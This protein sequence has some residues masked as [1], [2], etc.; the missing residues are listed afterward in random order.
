MW[1]HLTSFALQAVSI[2]RANHDTPIKLTFKT[3]LLLGNTFYVKE[4]LVLHGEGGG[5][6]NLDMQFRREM[7][8]GSLSPGLPLVFHFMVLGDS[9]FALS[10]SVLS[11]QS[12]HIA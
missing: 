8:D 9:V 12:I 10:N 3:S 7:D 5:P 6:A 1:A 11:V 2:E 4:Y